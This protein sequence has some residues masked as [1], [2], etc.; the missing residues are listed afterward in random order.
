M[1]HLATRH[2]LPPI[3]VRARTEN[4]PVLLKKNAPRSE[5]T[6]GVPPHVPPRRAVLGTR[7][8]GLNHGMKPTKARRPNDSSPPQPSGVQ[9]HASGSS[10]SARNAAAALRMP[11]SGR[12]HE[13]NP[14][15]THGD[16]AHAALAHA[17]TSRRKRCVS[18]G[19]LA[20]MGTVRARPAMHENY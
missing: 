19:N 6:A 5:R 10:T 8:G 11:G 16:K 18:S 13:P 14:H 9:Q 7:S 12:P 17:T 4:K 2:V 1:L 20:L 3:T 15:A